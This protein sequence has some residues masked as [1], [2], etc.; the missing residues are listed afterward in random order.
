MLQSA[1][2]KVE[3]YATLTLRDVADLFRMGESTV[4]RHVKS[5]TFP[6]KPIG[7][8]GK[9]VRFSKAEVLRHLRLTDFREGGVV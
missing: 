5:N 1:S 7:G 6:V 4:R 2:M 3:P 8:I 9:A